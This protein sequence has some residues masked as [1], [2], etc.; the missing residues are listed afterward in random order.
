MPSGETRIVW[1]NIDNESGLSP[2]DSFN[3]SYK[4]YA[5]K[6]GVDVQLTNPVANVEFTD[7]NGRNNYTT[8]IPQ[9]F[10]NVNQPPSVIVC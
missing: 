3:F 9:R 6:S 5:S 2:Q 1:D 4:A 7:R 10:I 8:P